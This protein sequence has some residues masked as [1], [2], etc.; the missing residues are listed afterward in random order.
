MG[1]FRPSDKDTIGVGC[2]TNAY[3]IRNKMLSLQRVMAVFDDIW[4]NIWK[5]WLYLHYEK[6][7]FF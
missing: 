1:V 7:R 3:Q 6:S 5:K 4:N 2:D